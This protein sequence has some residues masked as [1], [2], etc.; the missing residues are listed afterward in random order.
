[1]RVISLADADGAVALAF[2]RFGPYHRARLEAARARLVRLQSLEFSVVDETYAWA[3]VRIEEGTHVSVFGDADVDRKSSREVAQR[4]NQALDQLGPAVLAI[5]GWSHPAALGGLAW[6]LRNSRS[7]VLMSET[8]AGDEPR[9]PWR[10]WIKRR[11]VRLFAAALVGGAPQAAYVRALGMPKDAISPGYDV[12]DNVHFAKRSA[13][14]R[15][16]AERLRS[17]RDLPPAFFLASSR[18]VAKKNLLRL[19]DAY[20]LYRQRAGLDHWRLVLLGDGELR[21]SIVSRI[22]ELDLVEDVRLPGF[23]QYD[24]VPIYYGLA[25]AFVHASTSEPW[26][27]VIN[28]AMASGLPVIVSNRCGCV[29]D[30]VK[31]GVNGFTFD[32]CDVAELAGLMQRVAALADEQRH[33]M[34]RASQRII[35]DWGPE[36]FAE[37]LMQ[38]V[39]VAM[40]RPPPEPSWLDKTL[41]WMLMHR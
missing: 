29:P 8:T 10:E 15:A 12:V 28:E 22:A 6:A 36:R 19:L 11:V 1:V 33:A 9:R 18:F 40:R 4:V 24:E 14:T 23:K 35:A 32:P 30:L 31:D 39:Q 16:E 2:H 27:L 5:P 3:R 21:P 41:L 7:A 34:G 37:G 17:E 13:M 20:A 26:G 38:A 25:L